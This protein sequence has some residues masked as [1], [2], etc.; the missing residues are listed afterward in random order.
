[1]I[2]QILFEIPAMYET[3]VRSGNLIQIGGLLKDQASGKIVAH[4]QESG[5]A[6][7]LINQALQTATTPISLFSDVLNTGSSLYTAVQVQQIK[8]MIEGL[9]SLQIATLGVSLVGIGVSVAGFIYMHKRLNQL[10]EKID[11]LIDAVNAGFEQQHKTALRARLSHVRALIQQAEQAPTL[12]KPEHEYSRIAELLAGEASHFEGELEIVMNVQGK[13]NIELFWQ[14]AQVLLVC[15]STRI[16]CRLRTNEMRNA[17]TLSESVAHSYQNIFRRLTPLSFNATE[18]NNLALV[19]TLKDI[20]DVAATK[21]YLIDYLRMQHIDGRDYLEK[22]EKEKE[23]PI[24]L[25]K[26]A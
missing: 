10:D 9:K 22:I 11:K 15:N 1:M 19:N 17:L 3:A 16:D 26:V 25:L 2:S 8:G 13:I 4:L 20:A 23:Q 24:L 21:P 7:S 6:H 18:Q 14:L 12:S 5:L